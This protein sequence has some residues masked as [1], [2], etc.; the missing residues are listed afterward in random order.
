MERL[1]VWWK[2]HGRALAGLLYV[3]MESR[4]ETPSHPTVRPDGGDQQPTTEASFIGM[5]ARIS[6]VEY[7]PPDMASV[8]KRTRNPN[9]ARR[10]RTW[11]GEERE[12]ER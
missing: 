1:E 7:S 6:T 11:G 3:Q 2:R 4:P 9:M 8:V 10:L 5:L 12:A